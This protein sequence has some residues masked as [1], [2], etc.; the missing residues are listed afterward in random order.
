MIKSFSMKKE[1][2][3]IVLLVV[4][5]FFFCLPLIFP[6]NKIVFEESYLQFCSY[7]DL[8]IIHF[9]RDYQIP[10]WSFHFGGGYPFIKHPDNISLS[11]LFYLLILPYGSA[12]GLKLFL[13]FSYASGAAGF[14]S[15]CAAHFAV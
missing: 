5:S 4:S 7:L 14:F 1:L 12:N 15:F 3:L 6:L 2:I 11:P 8:N 10:L 9:F 13:L